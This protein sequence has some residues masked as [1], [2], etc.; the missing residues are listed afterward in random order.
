TE[1]I[2]GISVGSRRPCVKSTFLAAS[3]GMAGWRSSPRQK[4]SGHVFGW[5]RLRVYC[6]HVWQ[7][8]VSS[9]SKVAEE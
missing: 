9:C 8:C 5:R 1:L 2:T 6:G 3:D 4:D 7:T